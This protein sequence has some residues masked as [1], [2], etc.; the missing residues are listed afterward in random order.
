[1][2]NFNDLVNALIEIILLLVPLIFAITLIVIVWGVVKAWF[3]NAGD[4]TKVEEG[5]QLVL[6][7]VIALVFMSGIWGILRL[8]HNSLF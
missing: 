8:L 5:K 7:G 1:M 6:V 3:I 4:T 2:S